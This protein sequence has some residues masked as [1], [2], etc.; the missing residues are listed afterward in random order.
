MPEH[1]GSSPRVSGGFIN[2]GVHASL[3][4]IFPFEVNQHSS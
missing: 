4:E 3:A 1:A 2:N